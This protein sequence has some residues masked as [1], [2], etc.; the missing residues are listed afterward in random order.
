MLSGSCFC[1]EVQYEV[2]GEPFNK[3]ICHCV[4][5]RRTTGA[6]FLAWFSVLKSEFRFLSGT[7]ARFSS[8][9]GAE[10]TFCPRCGA[11]LTF[12]LLETD[13]IDITIGSLDEPEN[14]APK[15]Q[16]WAIRMLSW[17]PSIHEIKR[18]DEHRTDC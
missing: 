4:N 6:P 3:S 10:R 12:E 11:Q 8:S 18:Y 16:I 1:R 2:S 17:V 13:E 7:P 14:V 15:D 5:C 9:E